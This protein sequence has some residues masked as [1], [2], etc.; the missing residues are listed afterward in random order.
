LCSPGVNK[1]G[2]KQPVAPPTVK[3]FDAATGK[4]QAT[5]PAAARW[6]W[7]TP[8]GKTL[9]LDQVGSTTLWDL[10][11][12]K[13]R[14][15]LPNAVVGVA[16]PIAAEGMTLVTV[17]VLGGRYGIKAWDLATGKEQPL[18]KGLQESFAA[19][20]HPQPIYRWMFSADDKLLATA[21]SQQINLWD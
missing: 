16:P 3:L 13:P 19:V 11:M 18:A 20:P 6:L 5:L 10:A 4:E 8:D 9:V 1:M 7:F 12:N 14:A 15:S 21:C 2:E 17:G